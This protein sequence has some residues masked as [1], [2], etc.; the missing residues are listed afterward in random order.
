MNYR[1]SYSAF[2]LRRARSVTASDPEEVRFE[3]TEDAFTAEHPLHSSVSFLPSSVDIGLITAE[4]NARIGYR[5]D[6]RCGF[7]E[8]LIT[9][10]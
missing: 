6:P 7:L 2:L 9:G 1:F 5:F 4:W 10:A 8:P 3:I